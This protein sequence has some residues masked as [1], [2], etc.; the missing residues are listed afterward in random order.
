[1]RAHQLA[2]V[3]ERQTNDGGKSGD[4]KRGDAAAR[5]K[6]LQHPSCQGASNRIG[7]LH[8]RHL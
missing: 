5:A 2:A 3:R 7:S 6:L 4:A 8:D 1:M